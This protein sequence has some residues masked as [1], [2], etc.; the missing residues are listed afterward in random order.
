MSIPPA[1]CS[2][3]DAEDCTS[4]YECGSC[5]RKDMCLTCINNWL[6]SPGGNKCCP[7]C[8]KYIGDADDAAE[9]QAQSTY[10]DMHS[11][12]HPDERAMSPENDRRVRRRILPSSLHRTDSSF[13]SSRSLVSFADIW[14][15]TN[16]GWR[17][18][19]VSHNVFQTEET[20]MSFYGYN[21]GDT[22]A[23]MQMFQ[24]VPYLQSVARMP[25]ASIVLLG[26]YPNEITGSADMTGVF[27]NAYKLIWLPAG[28]NMVPD[29]FP[30]TATDEVRD[31][32][33]IREIRNFVRRQELVLANLYDDSMKFIKATGLL[34]GEYDMQSKAGRFCRNLQVISRLDMR[35]AFDLSSF[36]SAITRNRMDRA[37]LLQCEK[38]NL[39]TFIGGRAD[40]ITDGIQWSFA[41]EHSM[42]F[43]DNEELKAIR[44]GTLFMSYENTANDDGISN[45]KCFY[46]PDPTISITGCLFYYVGSVPIR[47]VH[48]I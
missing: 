40:R 22:V 19:Y 39:L 4:F 32:Y 13:G 23:P 31:V 30:N 24:Y 33:E 37:T 21:A 26:H 28:F 25:N 20:F 38:K 35:D 45:R 46:V 42:P 14:G 7:Y 34:V 8:R 5:N 1:Q 29:V 18:V 10:E 2:I 12:M 11:I 36:R 17:S 44:L 9:T 47:T 16:V 43:I 3:C 41:I 27:S 6:S 48:Y 15:E